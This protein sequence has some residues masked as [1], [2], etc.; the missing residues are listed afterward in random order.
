MAATGSFTPYSRRQV[1]ESVVSG[2]AAS[3]RPGV[4]ACGAVRG[5]LR[6]HN[7]EAQQRLQDFAE[8]KAS[9]DAAPEK[10]RTGSTRSPHGVPIRAAATTGRPRRH[11]PRKPASRAR[12]PVH[13]PCGI[14]WRPKLRGSAVEMRVEGGGYALNTPLGF[15]RASPIRPRRAHGHSGVPADAARCRYRLRCTVRAELRRSAPG[16]CVGR[17]CGEMQRCDSPTN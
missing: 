14:R 13:E 6:D 17:D 15:S 1:E 9:P 3:R 12:V 5:F 2:C 7:Q 10:T 16:R 4:L 11:C 8:F